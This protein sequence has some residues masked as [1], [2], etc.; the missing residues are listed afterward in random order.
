MLVANPGNTAFDGA[1]ILAPE[2]IGARNADF[3][4]PIFLAPHSSRWV[5]FYVLT[6]NGTEGRGVAAVAAAI[7]SAWPLDPVKGGPPA[8]VWLHDTDSPFAVS[9]SLR[10]PFPGPTLPD[11]GVGVSSEGLDAV[12]LDHAPQ[13]EPVRREAFLDWV[14]LGG[15][16]HLLPGA[17]GKLPV[18]GAGLEVLDTPENMISVG[19]GQ[20]VHHTIAPQEMSERFL[21]DHGFH[22]RTISNAQNPL[23]YDFDGPIFRKLGSLTKPN[24]SW[25]LVNLLV[26]AY[27]AVIGPVHNYYRRRLDYRVSILVFLGL[28][29]RV[30]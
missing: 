2:K 8:C 27:V 11:G 24:V 6:G 15:T 13:W 23:I 17:D 22:P 21:A 20:V 16:V 25:A 19:L 26:L 18:F 29:G 3:V 5:Q 28:C 30:L 9:G 4:Q 1:L 12:V 14:K 10:S 7:G